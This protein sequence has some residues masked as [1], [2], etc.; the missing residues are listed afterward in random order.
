[1]SGVITLSVLRQVVMGGVGLGNVNASLALGRERTLRAL[2]GLVG[3][4]VR[5]VGHRLMLMGA[6]V[7]LQPHDS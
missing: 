1:M 6:A 4:R 5:R 2:G 7:D 3:L